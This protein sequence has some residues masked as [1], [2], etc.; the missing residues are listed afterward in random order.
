MAELSS[1]RMEADVMVLALFLAG[2]INLLQE[3]LSAQH[4]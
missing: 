1:K 4:F 2:I 3:M